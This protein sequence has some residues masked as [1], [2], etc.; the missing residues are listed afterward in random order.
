VIYEDIQ[1]LLTGPGMGLKAFLRNDRLRRA[2]I[3]H[4]DPEVMGEGKRFLCELIRNTESQRG[5]RHALALLPLM[6]LEEGEEI[7]FEGKQRVHLIALTPPA[8]GSPVMAYLFEPARILVFKPTPFLTCEG[9]FLSLMA[10]VNPWISVGK[11]L[12]LLGR[13]KLESEL[14]GPVEVVGLS[15]GGAL[16]LH[17]TEQL[18]HLVRRAWAFNPPAFLWPPKASEAFRRLEIVHHPR[19]W[20]YPFGLFWPEGAKQTFLTDGYPI[21]SRFLAHFRPFSTDP[22]T[23]KARR[24]FLRVPLNLLALIVTPLLFG[25]FG[26][27]RFIKIILLR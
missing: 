20:V 27:L 5:R 26:L 6:G 11:S 13:K 21:H 17:F 23:A 12:F 18:P 4:S 7:E 16:V 19:D 22:R 24:S 10:D 14:K 15:L 25:C 8:L 2:V 9:H 1:T 3:G